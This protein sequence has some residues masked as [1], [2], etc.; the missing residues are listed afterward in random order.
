MKSFE[1]IDLAILETVSGGAAAVTA[2]NFM[3][4]ARALQTLNNQNTASP[5]PKLGAQIHSEFCG[6]LYPYAKSGKPINGAFG[7]IARGMVVSNGDK[8]CK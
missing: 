1:N 5:S 8:V 4:R 6:A 3:P 7:S 2:D